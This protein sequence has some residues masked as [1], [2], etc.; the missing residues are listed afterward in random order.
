QILVADRVA[1]VVELLAFD[2]RDLRLHTRALEVEAQWNAGDA[3]SGDFRR[4]ALEL[5]SV[6]QHLA[7]SLGQVARPRRRTIARDMRPDE[8]SLASAEL[9]ERVLEVGP[10]IPERLDFA[11][12][13]GEPGLEP[14]LDEELVERL[15]I[16][17][18]DF[19]RGLLGRLSS[20]LRQARSTPPPA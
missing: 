7:V 4:P 15:A 14:A 16:R 11:S 9:N 18:D 6:H 17:G 8:E 2:Q 3:A 5:P 20:G 1:L 10:A 13:E 12:G 19:F